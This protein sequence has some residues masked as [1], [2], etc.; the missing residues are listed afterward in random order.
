MTSMPYSHR[1]DGGLVGSR[2][3]VHIR[4]KRMLNPI[5]LRKAEIVYNFGLFEWNRVK[6]SVVW[7]LD[8]QESNWVQL[9]KTD[10]IIR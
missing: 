7:M 10:D 1:Q 5:A 8:S 3:L 9:F 2:F 4:Q 6:I